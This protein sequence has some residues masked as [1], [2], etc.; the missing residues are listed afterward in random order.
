MLKSLLEHGK[1]INNELHHSLSKANDELLRLKKEN[2][3][4]DL[5]YKEAL[6]KI[7]EFRVLYQQS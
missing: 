6:E 3:V 5:K 7:K 1:G 2:D 4:H